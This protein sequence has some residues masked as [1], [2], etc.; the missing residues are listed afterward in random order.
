[1][2]TLLLNPPWMKAGKRIESLVRKALYTYKM[3]ENHRKIVIALSGG[4][5]SL[6]L[7]LMLK[8]ISGRGFPPLD[9]YAVNIGGKYSC[10]AEVSKSYLSQICDRLHVPFTTIASPYESE[11]PECYPCSQARRRLL[12]QAAK[13]IGAT[14]IA[15]GHHRDDVV[16]TA[17]LNLLHK[18]EFAGMLPVLDMIH[19]GVTILRPLIF[20]PE[21][22]IRKFAKENGF[23]R[24]TCRCP[25]ISLRSKAEQGLKFLEEV[26]PLARHNIALAIYEQGSSKSQKN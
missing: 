22:W 18:A 14:A 16:Q 19:F 26:F 4:K 17:L 5:D 21:L 6:T 9:L 10:G 24:V 7:L 23:S 20:T 25:V 11:T 8:V 1:M 2:S 3:L 12:F 15:F 13:E